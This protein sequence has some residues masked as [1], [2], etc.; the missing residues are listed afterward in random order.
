M[1]FADDIVLGDFTSADLD[2]LV[3]EDEYSARGQRTAK[4]FSG[5]QLSFAISAIF[6]FV[7][8]CTLFYFVA[9]DIGS[10]E[11]LAP[12][13]IR[14]EFVPSNPLLSQA[15]EIIP[16]TPSESAD[17]IP[18]AE[19]SS[20]LPV[21]EP[22]PESIQAEVLEISASE[23]AEAPPVE[24]PDANLFRPVETISL[25]SVESVQRVLSNLQRNDTSRFTTYDCNKLEEEKEFS[26]CAPRD[27]RDYSALTRNPAYEFHKSEIEYSRSRETVT[28]LARQSAGVFEQLALSDLPPGLSSYVSEELEQGIETYSHNSS[29]A[30]NHMNTMVDKSAAGAM[31]RNLFDYWVQQQ[32]VQL[33]SR[34]VESRSD[35]LFRQRCRSYEKFIM[36][37]AISARCLSA[38][39]TPFGFSIKF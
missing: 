28:T 9:S 33:Q 22:Q 7:L 27:T 32:Y 38:G 10:V 26:D 4:L 17:P 5:M 16:E 34:R 6:H 39:E 13:L 25:P 1:E 35:R 29:R 37:P 19:S 8:V 12:G 36:S 21:A 20:A 31:A 2:D 15:E 24:N 3:D 30:L 23:I 18:L 11:E 14:V